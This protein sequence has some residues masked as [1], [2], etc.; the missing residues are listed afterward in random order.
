M[1]CL[2]TSWNT[3]KRKLNDGN[4][5]TRRAKRA[6]VSPH[7]IMHV[8]TVQKAVKES[9]SALEKHGGV[10]LHDVRIDPLLESIPFVR[11]LNTIPPASEN[12]DVVL[13]TRKYEEQFLREC[14]SNKERK[15][16]MQMQCECMVLDPAQPFIGVQF[17]LPSTLEAS[18]ADNREGMCLL[19]LRKTTQILF[20]QTIDRGHRVNAVI[21]K[22]GNICDEP[23]EY[24]HNA[25]L[26]CPPQ[27]PVNCMPLPMVA[28][29]RSNYEVVKKQGILWVVQKNVGYEDF[30]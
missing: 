2:P 11:L 8:E 18:S 24:H 29:Q 20:Y 22:H 6:Q 5:C 14:R 17:V 23:G 26:I 21:Q 7:G 30:T 16:V 9:L 3:N 1:S 25:M 15:C 13:V 19:C 12:G 10:E 27:G 4:K 28:H